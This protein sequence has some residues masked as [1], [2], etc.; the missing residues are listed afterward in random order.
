MQSAIWA[1]PR[2][3]VLRVVNRTI[4]NMITSRGRTERPPPGDC[5]KKCCQADVS[6]KPAGT[7]FLQ[8]G[9]VTVPYADS[10]KALPREAQS[11]VRLGRTSG[12]LVPPRGRPW[13]SG[14]WRSSTNLI[15][16]S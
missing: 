3:R 5:C 6:S 11:S 10:A 4:N 9:C 12:R 14:R 16:F 1:D 8:S 13:W 2:R 7:V 15:S